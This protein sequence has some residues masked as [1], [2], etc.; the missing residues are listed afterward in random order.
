MFYIIEKENQL[1]NLPHQGS[2]Y[3]DFIPLNDN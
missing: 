2:C 1:M 3:I